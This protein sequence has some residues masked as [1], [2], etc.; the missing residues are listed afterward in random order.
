[1]LRFASTHWVTRKNYSLVT[2]LNQ[3]LL[4]PADLSSGHG[5]STDAAKISIFGIIVNGVIGPVLNEP[6]GNL[7]SV[8]NS[9]MNMLAHVPKVIKSANY[10]L[11]NIEKIRKCINTDTTKSAIVSLVTSRLDYC[12]GILC[13]ITDE[14]LCRRQKIKNNATRVV[15]GSEKYDHTHHI[16]CKKIFTGCPSGKGLSSR[17]CF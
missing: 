2:L 15:S 14:L 8:F 11:R 1:M 5:F 10:Y 6:V 4:I 17:F 16:I 13:G 3:S 9:N 12:N 7:V